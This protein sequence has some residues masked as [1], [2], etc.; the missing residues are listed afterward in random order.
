MEINRIKKSMENPRFCHR[1]LGPA[2]Y[3]QLELRGFPIQSVAAS[4]SAK[5]A[6]S[7][8]L[9][10]GLRGFSMNEVELIRQ[11][12]GKPELSLSGN[13]L[14]IAQERK[15]QFSVSITHTRNYAAAVVIGQEE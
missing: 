4:F 7:K 11:E 5:E 9:G 3:A 10:V 14:G 13:A 8:A 12:N 6:F 1:V 15:L 2:E